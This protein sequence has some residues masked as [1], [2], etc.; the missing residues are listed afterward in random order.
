MLS[1][2]LW[3]L[4]RQVVV[5]PATTA[6]CER[7][8]RLNSLI[9]TDLQ[10]AMTDKRMN[11]LCVL[12]HHKDLLIEIDVKE[13]MTEFINNVDGRVNTFGKFDK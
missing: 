1:P 3:T 7:S 10:S 11:H 2:N 9:K 13:V 5:N 4:L 6:S 8:F 12:K